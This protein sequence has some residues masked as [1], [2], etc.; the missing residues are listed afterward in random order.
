MRPIGQGQL[1][2]RIIGT[3]KLVSGLLLLALGFGLFRAFHSDLGES[4]GRVIDMLRLDPENHYIHTALS[5]VSGLD[6]K[7][8][9]AIQA[10]TFVYAVLHLIEGTGLLLKKRWA[11]YMTV[12]ITGSLVPLEGYEVIH[13]VNPVKIA[14]LVVNLGIVIFLVW[15]LRQEQK[16][17]A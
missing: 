14:V 13:K 7:H 3:F 15:R 2:F 16:N 10:G 11:G 8:L 12:I 4:A 5:W 6:R 1:G 9:R 17:E